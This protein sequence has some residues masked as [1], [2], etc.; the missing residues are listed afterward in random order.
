MAL[1]TLNGLKGF[2]GIDLSDT[3]KDA[4]LTVFK[5]SVESSVIAFCDT[6]FTAK[7]VTGEIQDGVKA[8]VIVPQH[9]PIISVQAVIIYCDVTGAGGS[10]LDAATDYYFDEGAIILKNLTTPFNRG[11]VRLDY[12]W[13][14]GAVPAQVILA[15]YQ[16]VKAEYQR[17]KKNT[18]DVSSRS[19]GDE[20]ESYGVGPGG[21]WDAYTGLPK[22]IMAKL[23]P[24]KTYEF[25]LINTAQRNM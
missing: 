3:S 12:T 23:Q 21:A 22:Q 24:F 19:K 8:D 6:D 14:Y 13:G 17:H 16:S 7:T 20:S 15:V 1:T 10:T 5:D 9:S 25:P 2:L 18:E 4:L 11:I